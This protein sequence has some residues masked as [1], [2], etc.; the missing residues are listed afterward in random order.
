MTVA[1]SDVLIDYL[2]G[3][4]PMAGVVAGHV[5]SGRLAT[6]VVN[7]FELRSGLRS[8]RQRRALDDLLAATTLLPLEVAAADRAA[9]IRRELEARGKGIG[10]ADCL[11]AAICLENG[12]GLMTR[13]VQHFGRIQGLSLESSR[14]R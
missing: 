14:P 12:A 11:I 4:E 7:V 9:A 5:R 10:L 13:N 1:D 2:S 8:A 6:T 3:A